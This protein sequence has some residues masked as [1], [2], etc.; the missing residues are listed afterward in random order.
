MDS[1][2]FLPKMNKNCLTCSEVIT[3]FPHY[4]SY[5]KGYECNQCVYRP[6]C[7]DC[8]A[9]DGLIFYQKHC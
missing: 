2:Y 6:E 4:N 3:G 9:E 8:A 7:D 5:L 1:L